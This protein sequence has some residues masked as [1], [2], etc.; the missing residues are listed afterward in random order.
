MSGHSLPQVCSQYC[1]SASMWIVS[2]VSKA[3][4]SVNA[5]IGHGSLRKVDGSEQTQKWDNANKLELGIKTWRVNTS[6]SP[7]WLT[8]LS[9]H[10]P[11]KTQCRSKPVGVFSVTCHLQWRPWE[12]VFFLLG[13]P[14]W[15]QQHC[16]HLVLT[17][18]DSTWLYFSAHYT[19]PLV[20]F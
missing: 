9:S 10:T 20:P 19:F 17:W 13:L 7:P 18:L 15:L 2:S 1:V 5:D 16:A 8:P 4:A 11:K 6:S 3:G 14:V 12:F